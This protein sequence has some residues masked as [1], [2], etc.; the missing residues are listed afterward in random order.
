VKPDSRSRLYRLS[1]P[2]LVLIVTFLI[3]PVLFVFSLVRPRAGKTVVSVYHAGEPIGNFPIERDTVVDLPDAGVRIEFKT[4]RVRVV[5]SDCPNQ[6]CVRTGWVSRPGRSIVCVPNKVLVELRGSRS[7]Y[8]AE[9][10]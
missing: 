1:L 4:G 9:S 6:V 7:E 8:D 2:D 5:E 10:Y 3:L